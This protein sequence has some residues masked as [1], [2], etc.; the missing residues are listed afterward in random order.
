[1][2]MR[3]T[4]RNPAAGKCGAG[5]ADRVGAT[6]GIHLGPKHR[7]FQE[8]IDFAA[9]NRAAISALAAILARLVPGGKRTG[10]EYVALNPRRADRHVGSFKETE[11]ERARARQIWDARIAKRDRL[12]SSVHSIDGDAP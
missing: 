8:Q 10:G 11:K 12:A 1:M 6:I 3:A 9:I 4:K 7:I 5:N 2:T